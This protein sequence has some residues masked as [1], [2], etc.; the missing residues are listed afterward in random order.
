MKS[1]LRSLL[2]LP[3]LATLAPTAVAKDESISLAQCPAPVQAVIKVYSAKGTFETVTLDA[4]KK[5]GGPAVYEAKFS[6]RNGE[7]VELHIS[8]EGTVLQTEEKKPKN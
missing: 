4:K 2:I 5:S 1:I 7:R 3:T 8:P 6:L